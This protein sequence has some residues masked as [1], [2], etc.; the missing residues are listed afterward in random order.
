VTGA[1]GIRRPGRGPGARG[2]AA[3]LGLGAIGALALAALGPATAQAQTEPRLAAAVRLARDGLTDS[4][5]AVAGR[6][7]SGARP[8]DAVY[9]EAL[10][11]VA[12]VAATAEEKRLHLQR[13]AV[14]FSQSDWADDARLELAQMDYA[15]RDLPGTIRH[16]Q[17]LLAD[18][19]LSPLR[20]TAAL[21][22]ARAALDHREVPL[23]CQWAALGLEA[24]GSDLELRNQLDFQRQRC[25]AMSQGP[26]PPPPPP[27]AVPPPAPRGPQW[28]V[29]VAAFRTRERAT[30]V[31]ADLEGAGIAAV[32]LPDGGLFKVRAG[33][34]AAEREAAAALPAIRRRVGGNPFVVRPQ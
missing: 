23:A 26:A 12:L 11:T 6:V 9:P 27:A 30:Q 3:A 13:V 2:R 16:V 33:P 5:R 7:L 8:T 18:Y 4:A 24:A 20:A 15:A 28:F 31:V 10:Y 22:G 32:V 25:V 29:Q 19:P 21:W 1:A 14:E 34:Y 17:R